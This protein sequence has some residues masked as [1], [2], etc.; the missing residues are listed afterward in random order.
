MKLTLPQQDVYFEQ[1]MY[2]D[3]PI[4]NIGAK[5]AITGTISHEVLN[6]AYID[7][8]SQHDSY[9]SVISQ[10]AEEVTINILETHDSVLEYLD[11]SGDEN[12]DAH[13]N[14]FMQQ[15]F[16]V[17]LRMD[18]RELLHKFILLKVSQTEH[19]LFSVYHHIITDG[20]G[21]SLMF[22]RLVKNYNE[23][24]LFGAVTSEYPYTYRDFVLDDQAYFLSDD[25]QD[26]KNYWKEK[27]RQP[28]EQLLEKKEN[29][30]KPNESQRKEIIIK[31]DHY[32]RLEQVS[33]ELG[34]TTFHV[35]LGVLYLYFGR[36]DQNTDFTIGLPVLNRGKSIFKKTVGL[37]MGVSPL[38][39]QFSLED[40]FEELI[41][42]IKQQLRQ[43]YRHQ[44]FPLGKLIKELG[45]F[46]ENERL[47]NITLSYEKQ[48]YA[49][50][51]LNT[52]TKVIPLSH[53]SERVALAI[54]IRE[55]DPLED[56]KIDF[57]YN[58][59]YFSQAAISR[60]AA[61]FEA[62]L[63][64]VTDNPKKA[65]SQ[66]Q[67]LSQ[68]EKEQLLQNFNN[69]QSG[70]PEEATLLDYFKEQVLQAPDKTAV[71]NQ[72]GKFTYREL[73]LFSD[74]VAHYLQKNRTSA[75]PVPVAVLMDRSATLVATL[76][77]VL[78]SGNSY[79]PLDPSFP[80][81][82]L[83]YI[84]KHS[85]VAQII[86]G[87][88]I[89]HDLHTN[90]RI[91]TVESILEEEHDGLQAGLE[92][93]SSE[94]T[95]YIIYTSGS[96]G[97]PKGVAISHKALLNF[98]I[99][100][101][102]EPKIA[103]NDCLFSVTTQ[104]FDISILEFFTPLISGAS[105]Y[106]A[107]QELLSDPLAIVAKLDQLKPNIIQ[108]TPSFYQ[109]LY[110]AGWKGDK[111][112][113]ILCGGDLLSETLAGKLL[114]TSAEVWNMY[115][116][117]ETTIWSSCKKIEHA[118]EAS[119]IGK[120]IFN[121]E[122]YILDESKQLL[123]MGSPGTIYIG[124]YGLAQGY[125]KNE[126][127]T[128]EKFI[129]S[130][131]GS[132][133]KIYN[134]GDLGRWNEKGEIEF[135]G[136]NDNQ[137][138][139]RGYRIELGEIET[140]LNQLETVK[141]SVVIAQKKA[142]Q[143]AVLIAYVITEK[144]PDTVLIIDALRQELPEYMIP[145]AII[146]MEEFPLTPNKK[147]DRKALS[148]QEIT[149]QKTAGL[150]EKPT[151]AIE[152]K[153]YGFY[154]EVLGM[155]EISTTDNF[156]AL[157]GHSLNAVKLI[158]RINEQLQYR[159][160]LKEVFDYP[161]IQTLSKYLGKKATVKSIRIEPVEEQPYY[162]ITPSQYGIWLASQQEEKSMA[163]NMP[164]V[165][166]IQGAIR[167]EV[168]QQ[169]LLEIV[170]KHEILRTHFMETGG[171]PYQK[172]KSRDEVIVVI[173]EFFHEERNKAASLQK[174]LDT[175][176][177]LETEILLKAALF[178]EANGDSYLV[179]A[180]HHIAMDGW[181]LEILIREFADSYKAISQQEDRK[182]G[183]PAF[184][185]RDYAAWHLKQLETNHEKNKAFWET[186]LKGYSWE[187]R[188]PF[189]DEPFEGE[190]SGGHHDFLLESVKPA[191]L[192]EF[193][194]KHNLSLHT[195]LAGVFNILVY[196]MF[197]KRD[198][199]IGT[200]NSGRTHAELH[201]QLGMYVK[202]LPLRSRMHSAQTV[203]E[204]LHQTHQDLLAI[205]EHQD[206]PQTIQ[207][208]LK[209]DVLFVLQNPSFDYRTI[210]VCDGLQFQ[211]MPVKGSYSRLPLL[212][213]LW[214][215][216]ENVSGSIQYT[217]RNFSAQT[218]GL[219]QLKYAQ[220]LSE[221]LKNPEKQ[222]AELAIELPFEKERTIEIGLNF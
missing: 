53:H 32:N 156:F 66:Y 33:K 202:T 157:G 49:D 22:Q 166:K 94:D 208:Q 131:F 151:T 73:D 136:R 75:K 14:A 175:A 164:A 200:V 209:T 59:N 8:I 167:K 91:I 65:L 139:I 123:P 186:Y 180:T 154:T 168:L 135:L 81:D 190:H 6:Q 191:L 27:F 101:R 10:S 74:K 76:L 187:N 34:A 178:H 1:L 204:M 63:S 140:K 199:C 169:A 45:L 82:R 177:D 216:E 162:E 109:M 29:S 69:T 43:D 111:A 116:P 58:V 17:A 163:Y 87:R 113:K 142:D 194:R 72:E 110:N 117:T 149:I 132:N 196:K 86:A 77:G 172:I 122:F 120:P 89:D 171:I 210:S 19:Y 84:I 217:A 67:Y 78:K 143:E 40:N 185:F 130:P 36:K 16:E 184:Q 193:A 92:R 206:L 50:H 85:G 18:T 28:Q 198:F 155:E 35:I 207:N 165:F 126:E 96:T 9:R 70:F 47:F 173:E 188:L 118:S 104:S 145:H 212:V 39:I 61:H 137:V 148:L 222:L 121:T 90:S 97:S 26:D 159:I 192:Q 112:I 108:A 183:L 125:F 211:M 119:V 48:N 170:R 107:S 102:Q 25:Y 68:T 129:P 41:R 147:I 161:T 93:F 46:H 30:A 141:E 197:D 64:A 174:Y 203:L 146:Q 60:L 42:N 11:F 13:A 5:I 15:K 95:A 38:R 128:R 182:E 124:G 44:R 103:E 31:R 114:E 98:L 12:P 160:T 2:P 133:K 127:L 189:E 176:F 23:I 220:L 56:V 106:V 54:Y 37:F 3:D 138:K 214:I 181:S 213:T 219:I 4:Y 150:K 218:I 20:W 134:T 21:T 100:I 195:I 221:I 71:A 215:N 152:E 51:F 83:E 179:F 205:D 105:L 115:G 99:S 201:D 7:L 79:I 24:M 80:K 88:N 55:F 144:A 158:N 153:L 62:L 57:D 52:E